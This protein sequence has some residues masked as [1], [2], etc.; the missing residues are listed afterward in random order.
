MPAQYLLRTNEDGTY[1]HVYNRGIENKTIFNDEDD[2][3]VFLGFLKEYL[4]APPDIETTKKVFNI[5]GRAFRGTPHMPKNYFGKLELVAYNLMPNHFHLLLHQKTSDSLEGFVRSLCT[6]YSMYFNK[7]YQRT[8]SLF[9]G[10]YKLALIKDET[11]LLHLPRYFIKA[12]YSSSHEHF[13]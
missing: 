1:C 7:K 4:S 6:R 9:Q 12:G 3:N 8:G 2:Y 5:N 11:R 10:P 13:G